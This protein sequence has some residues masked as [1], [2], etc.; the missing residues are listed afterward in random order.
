MTQRTPAA[1]PR[2][3]RWFSGLT[4]GLAAAIVML[5]ASPVPAQDQDEPA[6]G[7]FGEDLTEFELRIYTAAEGK[8]DAML[9]RFRDHTVDLFA[10]HGMTNIGYWTP[11]E[12]PDGLLYYVLGFPDRDAREASW[13]AFIADPEWQTAKTASESDGVLVANIDSMVLQATDF[14]PPVASFFSI[15]TE[16]PLFDL[17]IY[18]ASEGNLPALLDRFR[19]HTMALFEKHGMINLPYWTLADDQ[20]DADRML[21][22]FLAH[23][24]AEAAAASFAAFREDPDWIAARQATEERAG[25]SLTVEGGVRSV[26][27][28]PT[29]FSP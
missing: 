29:D 17:R 3:S 19:N 1:P 2:N 11:V 16:Q 20:D 7:A 4:V 22:Y 18:T 9:A 15:K 28:K 5:P 24:D 12:N 13:A 25:G 27:L 6:T 8:F 14:S 21:Y 23:D 10:K 26:F